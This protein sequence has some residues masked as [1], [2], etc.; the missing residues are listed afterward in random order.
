MPAEITSANIAMVGNDCADA[1]YW[2]WSQMSAR[3]QYVQ[4]H[5]SICV[6]GI[7]PVGNY[8]LANHEAT[9]DTCT[10]NS[11][12]VMYEAYACLQPGDAVL[13]APGHIRMA[14]EAA[15]VYRNPDG[16]INPVKSYVITHEQGAGCDL[17]PQ[18]HSTCLVNGKYTFASLLQ[19]YYIPITIEAFGEVKSDEIQ[20]STSNTDL[21]KTGVAAGVISSNYRINYVTVEIIDASGKVLLD[22]FGSPNVNDT[23]ITTFDLSEFKPQVEALAL[24]AGKTYTYKVTLCVASQEV[25][26]QS[27]QFTA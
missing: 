7:I 8:Q 20:V 10:I 15:Y 17:L 13:Y 1:I 27:F 12:Q 5:S 2:A 24:A 22:A 16:T 11:P 4:T 19:N 21:T 3:I 9:K 6:N 26:V 18:R 23:H 25:P 14:A